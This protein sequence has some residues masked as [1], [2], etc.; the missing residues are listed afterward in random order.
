LA[1]V[2]GA[3]DQASAKERQNLCLYQ[4]LGSLKAFE[5]RIE[6]AVKLVASLPLDAKNILMPLADPI[7][8]QWKS[9]PVL[10]HDFFSS[11]QFQEI[12]MQVQTGQKHEALL[13]SGE[14]TFQLKSSLQREF[15]DRIT[16]CLQQNIRTSQSVKGDIARIQST[17]TTLE[18][19]V[20]MLIEYVHPSTACTVEK[21]KDVSML[22]PHASTANKVLLSK[23]LT[24]VSVIGSQQLMTSYDK[25]IT[26]KGRSRKRAPHQSIQDRPFSALNISAL[27]FWTEYKYGR[28][29]GLPLQQLEMEHGSKWRSD[30]RYTKLDGSTG[31]SLKSAWSLQK[32]IYDFIEYLLQS[33]KAEEEALS[34]VQEIFDHNCWKSGK[35]KLPVCIKLF[36]EYM[37]VPK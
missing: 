23:A 4:A 19:S 32:P 28:N 12:V 8:I 6:H 21:D 33:G 25:E 29:Q 22:S 5:R 14:L 2:Q 3:Y 18:S 17:M 30:S 15:S 20:K 26:T 35:P 7:Y 37:S 9:F 10:N 27:D 36:R 13:T 24:S 11:P 16:P 1:K 34:F 31:T